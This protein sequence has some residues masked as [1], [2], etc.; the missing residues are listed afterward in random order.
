MHLV[1]KNYTVKLQKKTKMID[2]RVWFNEIVDYAIALGFE[3]VT[4]HTSSASS[5]VDWYRYPLNKPYQISIQ[6]RDWETMCYELLHEI[7]HH[8]L[9]SNLKEYTKKYPAAALA[10]RKLLRE[11]ITKYSRRTSAMIDEL[12]EEFD[13]WDEAQ[14]IAAK[15]KIPLHQGNFNKLKI[16]LLTG[17]VR[18][19]GKKLNR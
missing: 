10:E 13:A 8:E 14:K 18:Y 17:Y 2:W 9:R 11:G 6:K 12:Q 4:I 16:R 5:V 1:M 3:N 7:G 19:Y 15:L